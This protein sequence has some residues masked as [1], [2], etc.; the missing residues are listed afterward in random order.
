MI[1]WAVSRVL[2]DVETAL[3]SPIV[4]RQEPTSGGISRVFVGRMLRRN[5]I[6]DVGNGICRE[7][8]FGV[9]S[10]RRRAL[11][12]YNSG[13]SNLRFGGLRKLLLNVRRVASPNRIRT[14]FFESLPSNPWKGADL[15]H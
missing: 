10:N 3:I 13:D 12:E 7:A 8:G 11:F 15:I 9:F 1:D 4:L 14:G 5:A 6:F 2:L